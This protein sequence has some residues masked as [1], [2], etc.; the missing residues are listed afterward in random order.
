[1]PFCD[2]EERFSALEGFQLQL[3]GRQKAGRNWEVIRYPLA[4]EPWTKYSE[5]FLKVKRSLGATVS[6]DR[7]SEIST[8][9]SFHTLLEK[10]PCLLHR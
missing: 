6:D 1:M 10:V 2:S 8:T 7:F 9:Y 5:L 4:D 3:N